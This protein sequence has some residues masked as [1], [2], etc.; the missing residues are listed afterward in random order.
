MLLLTTLGILALVFGILVLIA[1]DLLR[2]WSKKLDKVIV[3]LDEK[4]EKYRVSTGAISIAVG[5]TALY[6]AYYLKT[7]YGA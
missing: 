4:I 5:V 6:L 7:K 2:S 3:E 1:P